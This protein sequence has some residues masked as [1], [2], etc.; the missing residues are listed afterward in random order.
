MISP[1]IDINSLVV[2]YAPLV[3]FHEKETAFPSS[4]EW[5][6]ERS[7]LKARVGYLKQPVLGTGSVNAV[8]LIAQEVNRLGPGVYRDPFPNLPK[9]Y[10]SGSSDNFKTPFYLQID[11]LRSAE[12][13]KGQPIGN[14]G[15]VTAPCY[16]HLRP[17]PNSSEIDIQYW[18]FYPYNP[19]KRYGAGDHDGD[20]E[21]ITVRTNPDGSCPIGIYFSRHTSKEGR[22]E[23]SWETIKGTRHP[24]IY[25]ALGSHGSYAK[26]G[27]HKRSWPRPDDL[28]GESKNKWRCWECLVDVGTKAN[29]T[30]GNQWLQFT[31]RW[32]HNTGAKI[33][34]P[35][36]VPGNP[37][38]SPETPSFKGAWNNDGGDP[39][40]I[41]VSSDYKAFDA[42]FYLNHYPDLMQA[43][44]AKNYSAAKK[45]WE[46]HGLKEGRR[47]SRE[48]DVKFYLEHHP[49][50]VAA[51]GADNYPEALNHWLVHGLKEGRRSSREFDVKFYL[52]HHPDLVA[53]FGICNY[54]SALEHWLTHG[55]VE[56]RRSIPDVSTQTVLS[57]MM[58]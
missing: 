36:R 44:D 18:F 34:G 1:K 23:N 32:G 9:V 7:Q 14:D 26:A 3:H 43:F 12:A 38:R 41:E 8:T 56:G 52:E 50:L 55:I 45:H 24:V 11:E 33:F 16:V 46:V 15:L 17:A 48:F 4:V 58:Q 5:F 20:W 53:A 28:T 49:D 54:P 27:T 39:E 31:G 37:G 30:P 42:S 25:S 35:F 6:F 51:F 22:W 10:K 2:R 21:H 40:S 13:R 19:M 47:S 29:P 57:I